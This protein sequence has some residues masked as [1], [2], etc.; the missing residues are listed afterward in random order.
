M[1]EFLTDFSKI[2][3]YTVQMKR[4]EVPTDVGTYFYGQYAVADTELNQEAVL[5][6]HRAFL[7]FRKFSIER[8][9]KIL[10]DI[11]DLLILE[12]EKLLQ[13]MIMEGHPRKL[14]EWEFSGMLTAHL[15]ESLDYYQ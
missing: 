7:Q 9:R 1:D 8:R 13:L 2:R 15:S 12:K 14:S 10:D 5:S 6:A 3:E 4:G 11:R